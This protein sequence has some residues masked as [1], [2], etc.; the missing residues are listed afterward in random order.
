MWANGQIQKPV[1]VVPKSVARNW[2][3][4]IVKLHPSAKVL[5]ID[6]SRYEGRKMS[7]KRARAVGGPA[8]AQVGDVA[9]LD[10]KDHILRESGRWSRGLAKTDKAPDIGR[11]TAD[12]VANDYDFILVSREAFAWMPDAELIR[13][14]TYGVRAMAGALRVV[15]FRGR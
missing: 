12:A 7:V 11:K 2:E 9:V 14:T 3:A 6:E 10:G 13:P 15:D 5:I 4:E 1:A 8:N